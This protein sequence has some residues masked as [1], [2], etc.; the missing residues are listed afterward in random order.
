[1]TDRDD[2]LPPDPAEVDRVREGLADAVA[3]LVAVL[4]NDDA[5]DVL[6]DTLERV[7]GNRYRCEA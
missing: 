3:A 6:F 2:A 7:T 4:G 5:G 1:M